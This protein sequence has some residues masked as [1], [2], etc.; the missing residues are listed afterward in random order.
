MLDTINK[1]CLKDKR[2]DLDKWEYDFK[3]ISFLD[4]VW[5]DVVSKYQN[6]IGSNDD[7]K[8]VIAD[9]DTVTDAEIIMYD[10]SLVKLE[11]Y[12]ADKHIKKDIKFKLKRYENVLNPV[13]AKYAIKGSEA[14][15]I[16]NEDIELSVFESNNKKES[17]QVQDLYKLGKDVAVI[18]NS[19]ITDDKSYRLEFYSNGNQDTMK[20]SKAKVIYKHKITGEI[21]EVKDL[22]KPAPGFTINAQ[23]DLV[24]TSIKK[25][26]RSINHFN[27]YEGLMDSFEGIILKDNMNTGKGILDVTGLGLNIVNV[28]IDHQTVE[29]PKS[30]IKYNKYAF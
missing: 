4:N 6:G 16:T 29:I 11:K 18:D 9:N 30:L 26:V 22:L 23:G 7:L 25:T 15:E 24:N 1:D 14:I 13:N 21:I 28:N 27:S 2:W 10:K 3:S 8:V 5:D 17:R 12:V 20:V 19:K